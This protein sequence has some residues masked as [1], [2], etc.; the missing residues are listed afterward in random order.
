MLFRPLHRTFVDSPSPPVAA[1]P[2]FDSSVIH[3]RAV[4]FEGVGVVS[5]PASQPR[6]VVIYLCAVQYV[7]TYVPGRL[8]ACGGVLGP[9]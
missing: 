2:G 9:H 4:Q 7:S 8:P 1:P 3:R 5:P 6:T